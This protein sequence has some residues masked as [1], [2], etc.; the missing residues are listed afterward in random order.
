MR[1]INDGP[2]I[3]D[4]LIQAHEDGNVVFF[5]GAGV[6][7]PAGLPLFGQLVTLI[8]ERIGETMTPAETQ[9]FNNSQFDTT[10]QLLERRVESK[11]VRDAIAVILTATNPSRAAIATH[12][13]LLGLA[14]DSQDRTRLVTT[15]VDRL[16][17]R[18]DRKKRAYVAPHLPI[19][20]RSAWNGVAYLHGLLPSAGDDDP[21]NRMILSSGDFGLAYLIERWASRF[22]SELFRSFVVCF[23]GYSVDDPVLR[24]MVD[25]LWADRRVGEAEVPVFAFASHS[26]G[27]E[28]EAKESWAAK[29]I[30]PIQYVDTNRHERLHKTLQRWSRVYADGLNGKQ[31]IV[32]R[33]ARG[34]PSRIQGDGQVGRVLWGLSDTTGM[35]A[36][37]F[38]ELPA[39]IEWLAELRQRDFE[40]GDLPR[41]GVPA[42]PA[43]KDP[44]KF[45][46][47]AR[48]SSPFAGVYHKLIYRDQARDTY[49]VLDG[50]MFHLAAWIA[51]NYLDTA[52]VVNWIAQ[53]GPAL[54]PT[55]RGFILRQLR[56][57]SLPAFL[58][59]FWQVV[60]SGRTRGSVREWL[61]DWLALLKQYGATLSLRTELRSLL[62][63]LAH[64]SPSRRAL[65][66]ID[67]TATPQGPPSRLPEI[68]HSEVVL[69]GGDHPEI[70]I[71][72]AAKLPVWAELQD[73]MIGEFGDLL[74]EAFDLLYELGEI[75]RDSD[76][77]YI[78]RPSIGTSRQ[79]PGGPAWDVLVDLCRDSMTS[80]YKTDP[81]KARS[82]IGRWRKRPYPVFRRLVFLMAATTDVLSV[83]ESVQLLR[84]DGGWWLWSAETKT[85]ALRL[86]E[87]LA[88]R[89]RGVDS[90]AVGQL[91]VRGPPRSRFRPDIEASYLKRVLAGEVI[92][93]LK[94]FKAA[95]A[96]L[97]P[98]AAQKLQKLLRDYPMF[99]ENRQA[100]VRGVTW[101]GGGSVNDFRQ[102]ATLTRERATL[103]SELRNR[104]SG[105]FFY[106]DDWRDICEKDL[107]LAIG[108][109]TDLAAGDVWAAEVWS[110][111]LHVW[112]QD[113]NVAQAWGLVTPLLQGMPR[114][115]FDK[116]L[117]GVGYLLRSAGKTVSF[118]DNQFFILLGRV[119]DAQSSSAWEATDD[120]VGKAINDAVGQAIQGAFDLWYRTKPSLGAGLTPAPLQDLF[121]RIAA[122]PPGALLSGLAMIASNL[123]SLFL[124]DN[125][126][127]RA[128]LLPAFDWTAGEERARA[129]WEGYL[130][131]PR[132]AREL[133]AALKAGF[134]AT[135]A[136]YNQ[137]TK[138]AEQY[139]GLLI[140]TALEYPDLLSIAELRGA[141]HLVPA[142][143]LSSGVQVL[144][145]ALEGAGDRAS[146]LWQ[147]RVKP[148]LIGAWPKS[149]NRK[150]AEQSTWF[151]QLCAAAGAGYPDAVAT[152]L[153]LASETRNNVVAF[154]TILQ[155]EL[156][157][158]CP[159]DTLK[160]LRRL[161]DTAET[162]VTDDLRRLLD[163]LGIAQPK[164]KKLAAY[165]HL[166]DFAA[167]HTH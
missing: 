2:D 101:V 94:T 89:A 8:Y 9:A 54:H 78:G 92:L 66:A 135:A 104:P 119:V 160:L 153:P 137:L 1:F 86:I 147:S 37:V 23:V 128:H 25:A 44:V 136:H 77:S 22:V 85:E 130:W 120:V 106:E 141:L 41:F 56:K 132:L 17:L 103:V 14:T 20:K 122:A 51:E 166:A 79:T 152:I 76:F 109:L 43:P 115:P 140:W 73:S 27:G 75:T 68:V 139:V 151:G 49:P 114:E 134:I 50:P 16:F 70:W 97:A 72:E 53:D 12:R 118:N 36:K 123:N 157:K 95:G 63:P 107:P 30:V 99:A 57:G 83:R 40:W 155:K 159:A 58:V 163:E 127:S 131:N 45:S 29:G 13:A 164:L 35:S 80:V 82:E 162:F 121:T 88:V 38:A 61:P 42:E 10:I 111:A 98:V 146:E 133:F 145:T 150:T 18:A 102:I 81:A 3:P 26:Q 67:R 5:C 167:A 129:A 60:S 24:Y 39:P 46:F 65:F 52:E 165:K 7:Y 124:V 74:N 11:L 87:R 28:L 116:V 90:R 71:R 84:E 138:H 62:Q 19:P 6:S 126:W 149:V 161:V 154:Q 55:F 96:R 156:G 142:K 117:H 148:I 93:R 33:D 113:G 48:P 31:A 144:A 143:G 21:F 110:D 100:A 47:V 4:R 108:A 158:K 34:V 112:A 59:P 125:D 91:I 69:R 105:Q 15:N 64:F 32:A